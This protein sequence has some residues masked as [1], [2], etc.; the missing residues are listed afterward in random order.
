MSKESPKKMEDIDWEALE[1]EDK[2]RYAG[3]NE[4]M[5][6]SHAIDKEKKQL[7]EE[8][9][10]SPYP[11]DFLADLNLLNKEI[12]GNSNSPNTNDREVNE[13]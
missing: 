9:K 8:E 11:D 2:L 3:K 10:N 7:T 5:Y 4:E 1:N 12:K 13:D 6:D